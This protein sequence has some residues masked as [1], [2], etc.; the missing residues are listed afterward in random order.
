[1]LPE[2]MGHLGEI[3]PISRPPIEFV[4]GYHIGRIMEIIQKPT[5]DGLQIRC[6]GQATVNTTNT[7]SKGTATLQTNPNRTQQIER[8]FVVTVAELE[9]FPECRD[10]SII[11]EPSS[12][13]F[14]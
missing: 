11:L 12:F 7:R 3:V 6:R 4:L 14:V 8:A 2:E 9:P 5:I 13:S 10:R 1:V